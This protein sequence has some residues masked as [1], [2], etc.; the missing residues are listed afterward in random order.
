MNQTYHPG[1]GR[2]PVGE[3]AETAAALHYPCLPNWAPAFAGVDVI[4]GNMC[5]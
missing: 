1:E 2:G 5:S 4:S 3:V